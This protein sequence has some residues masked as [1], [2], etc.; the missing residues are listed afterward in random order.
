MKHENNVKIETGPLRPPS[1]AKSV[2]IRV[3]RNCP[4]NK[5][6]FCPAYKNEKFSL[7]KVEDIVEEIKALALD[8]ENK[9]A[10][11][12]FLQDAD[13]LVLTND[14][15]VEI[16]QNVKTH[17]PD[18]KRITA[19]SRSKTLANKGAAGLKELKQA[20]LTRVHVG[21]ESGADEVLDFMQ[22]G[23][24]AE[25]QYLGC[26]NVKDAGLELCCYIMP[27]LG[28]KKYS[29]VHAKETG[30]LIAKINPDHVRMRTCFVLENTPLADEYNAGNFEPLSETEIVE[31]IKEI[32]SHLKDTAIRIIS[33]HRINLLFDLDGQLPE[34]YDKL[35]GIIDRFLEM[36]EEDKEIFIAGRRLR[37]I[38][39]LDEM[40]NE[41]IYKKLK[42]VKHR[43]VKKTPVSHNILY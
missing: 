23:V 5:C 34:D 16:I 11:T 29:Q 8:P 20:G 37:I 35:V 3:T 21:F 7:R 33:D 38:K 26:K 28:G 12:I 25:K 14:K 31:E 1:E 27:G 39:Y 4:W 13:A 43:Y 41:Y 19:Y 30:R 40:K 15:L 36:S 32:L 17:F 9:D 24:T 22:K 10:E 42:D 6:S 2:L 18:I